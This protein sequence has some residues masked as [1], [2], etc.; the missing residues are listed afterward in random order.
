MNDKRKGAADCEQWFYLSMTEITGS[1][2]VDTQTITEII[3]EGIITAKK[4]EDDQWQFDSEA[5]RRIR[6][7]LRL[8]RDLGVNIAGAGLALE[9]IKQIE[10]L[11][12]YLNQI[13]K[14]STD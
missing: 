8:N 7:V 3:D 9:L 10:Q 11:E 2:G 4:D 12:N 14:P 5:I 13:N 1:F 6:T